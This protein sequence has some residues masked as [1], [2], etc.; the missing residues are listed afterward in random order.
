MER[1]PSLL[2]FFR[3]FTARWFAA[4]SGSLSVPLAIAA[5]FVSNDLAK[6]GLYITAVVCFGASAFSVWRAE[7]LKV[8][9]LEDRVALLESQSPRLELVFDES[10]PNC[11]KDEYYPFQGKP[12]KARRWYIGI[13]NASA[14]RSADDVTVR[15]IHSWFV[16]C[17]IEVSHRKREAPSE[18]NPVMFRAKTLHPH[19]CEYIEMFG[20]GPDPDQTPGDVLKREHEFVIEARARD[21]TTV[22]MK[23]GSGLI[24]SS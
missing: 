6:L 10:D 2:E 17:T 5:Y 4:M 24:T 12:L 3:S 13:R 15:A 20:L 1:K 9:A 14:Q 23:L 11:V 21:A 16:D 18:K 7:R 19:A 8:N 22:T